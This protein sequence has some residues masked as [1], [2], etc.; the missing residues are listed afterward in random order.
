MLKLFLDV[1]SV[2]YLCNK[3]NAGM[4]HTPP[5]DIFNVSNVNQGL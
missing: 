5:W 4:Q 1:L 3:S 2:Y